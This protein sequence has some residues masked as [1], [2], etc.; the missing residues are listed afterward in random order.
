MAFTAPTEV[1]DIQD[2]TP[3]TGLMAFMVDMATGTG[4]EASIP[5]MAT[6]TV[7]GI[8]HITTTIMGII[9]TGITEMYPTATEDAVAYTPIPIAHLL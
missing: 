3:R 1:G 7:M 4:T 5:T 2:F 6:G 9:I 8:T